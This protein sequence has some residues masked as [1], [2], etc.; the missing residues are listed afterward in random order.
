MFETYEEGS[1][2]YIQIVDTNQQV[3]KYLK[4]TKE[5]LD[6]SVFKGMHI[7]RLVKHSICDFGDPVPKEKIYVNKTL[8]KTHSNLNKVKAYNGIYRKLMT[9]INISVFEHITNT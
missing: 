7:F 5:K 8:I 3:A 9:S 6:N 1:P 2:E 4:D